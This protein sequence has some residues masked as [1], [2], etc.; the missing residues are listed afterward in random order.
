M[1]P[2]PR[3]E[4]RQSACRWFDSGPG[5]HIQLHD[6]T[7]V[8]GIARGP[9]VAIDGRPADYREVGGSGPGVGNPRG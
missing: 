1:L 7:R 5:H 3:S 9:S 8:S 4:L 6:L 2:V